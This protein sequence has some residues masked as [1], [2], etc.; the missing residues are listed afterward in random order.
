MEI[1]TPLIINIFIMISITVLIVRIIGNHSQNNH[2]RIDQIIQ[3]NNKNIHE[4]IDQVIQQN[5]E[6]QVEIKHLNQQ[7]EE[8]LKK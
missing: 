5:K 1:L 4:Q 2:K 6:M 7:I 8:I 3:Q